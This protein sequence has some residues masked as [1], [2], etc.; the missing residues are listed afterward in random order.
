MSQ[1]RDIS[2]ADSVLPERVAMPATIVLVRDRSRLR[3]TWPNGHVSQID[4]NRLRGACRR[5][6]CARWRVHGMLPTSFE[7]I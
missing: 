4:A 1:G 6:E 7:S 5:A 3:L 2:I